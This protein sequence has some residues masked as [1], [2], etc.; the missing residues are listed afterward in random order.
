MCGF[1]NP[2]GEWRGK[3]VSYAI[4]A[5]KL[6]GMKRY[7]HLGMKVGKTIHAQTDVLMRYAQQSENYSALFIT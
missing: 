3:S 2:R 7:D 5:K 1:R 6:Y 4:Q